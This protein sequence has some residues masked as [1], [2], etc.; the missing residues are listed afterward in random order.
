MRKSR[1]QGG[2]NAVALLEPTDTPDLV[3]AAATI[4][5]EV[6][7][8]RSVDAPVV[9]A[10]IIE[11]EPVQ[12]ERAESKELILAH[13][14]RVVTVFSPK[15]GTGTTTIA[16]N[17]A[18]LLSQTGARVCLVDL[19]LDF[20][21]VGI[22]MRLAPNRTIADMVNVALDADGDTLATAVVTMYRPG[23]DCVLAPVNPGDAELVGPEAV[24]RLI[25]ALRSSY[26][27]VVIDTPSRF[28][29]QVLEA[30]DM[31]DLHVLV[32]T[33]EIPALKNLRLT[34]DTLDLLGFA[35]ERQAVVL[36]KFDAK[37]GLGVEAARSVLATSRLIEVPS[38]SDAVAAA[39]E[40][41]PLAETAASNPM[42]TVLREFV[43]SSD[44]LPGKNDKRRSWR[45]FMIWRRSR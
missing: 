19:S 8:D 39:N 16:T 17:L 31:S 18:V 24:S 5:A 44:Y 22:G 25:S 13:R 23:L 41:T 34:M 27:A 14:A 40:G 10:E 6:D 45:G 3:E 28:S 15:G 20:G 2:G 33:P 4:E 35:P 30:L 1:Q 7:L 36:N 38:T 26:D 29:E 21:D 37:N 11:P 43:Q 12:P 9:E 32:T 42:V